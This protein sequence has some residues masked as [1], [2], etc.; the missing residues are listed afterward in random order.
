MKNLWYRALAWLLGRNLAST[1]TEVISSQL[2]EVRPLPMGVS[3]FEDWAERI[4]SGAM[5]EAD[6]DS[7]KFA[8]CNM[9]MQMGHTEHMKADIHFISQLRKVAVN[10]V[11]D[12]IRKEISA[13]VKARTAEAEAKAKEEADTLAALDAD[14][15]RTK[16]RIES[17]T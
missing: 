11:A 12:S 5:V 3:E 9:L 16:Q 15:E 1:P 17:V 4:I 8:L 7:Q 14:I 6:K 13:K 10:Q 2:H